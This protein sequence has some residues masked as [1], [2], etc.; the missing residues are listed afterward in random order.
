MKNLKTRRLIAVLIMCLLTFSFGLV[1]SVS[2]SEVA[3]ENSSGDITETV[4]NDE[5]E[6]ADDETETVNED[7]TTNEEDSADTSDAA[8]TDTE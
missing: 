2:A 4:L 5:I 7:A 6:V 1:S 3:Q 8:T